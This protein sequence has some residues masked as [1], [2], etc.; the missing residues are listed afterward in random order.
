L[1]ATT[2]FSDDGAAIDN[3]EFVVAPASFNAI[4]ADAAIT[5]AELTGDDEWRDRGVALASARDARAWDD[6]QGLWSDVVF[7]G[8]TVSSR[9]PT[10]DATLP[11]LCVENP[12]HATRALRQLTDPTRF[13]SPFGPRF[14]RPDNPA[15]QPDL[16][17]RGPAWPQLN[18]LSVLAAR[19]WGMA[20]T[21]D[22]VA[23][24]TKL[25][26]LRSSFAEYWNPESGEGR[27]AIP[28]T[29]A[30]VAAAL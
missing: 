12:E 17:W 3:T 13:G 4:A 25:G 22:D 11:A 18:Y 24:S 29:W 14:V 19:R 23:R 7:T 8:P 30:A 2:V 26:A 27:G 10:S 15:Y 21:A 16:Y 20:R 6:E 1:L 28:Q 5:L 9:L